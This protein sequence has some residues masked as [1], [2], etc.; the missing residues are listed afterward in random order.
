METPSDRVLSSWRAHAREGW[1]VE[2]YRHFRP[3][4][5]LGVPSDWAEITIDALDC[6]LD[7]KGFKRPDKARQHRMAYGADK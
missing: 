1:E 2:K 5:I 6:V 7:V 3:R 4:V